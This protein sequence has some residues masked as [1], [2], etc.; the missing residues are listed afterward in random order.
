MYSSGELFVRSRDLFPELRKSEWNKHQNNHRVR[1]KAPR[2][3]CK[4]NQWQRTWLGKTFVADF[5]DN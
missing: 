4:H 2:R 3:R 1:T 5:D